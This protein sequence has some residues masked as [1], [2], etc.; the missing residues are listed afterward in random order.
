MLAHPGSYLTTVFWRDL[1]SM[2]LSMNMR[3]R[4]F[5]VRG[6]FYK[7]NEKQSSVS[8]D[9][10]STPRFTQV[11]C[12]RGLSLLNL[13]TCWRWLRTPHP[14]T[15]TVVILHQGIV[16][17]GSIVW[18]SQRQDPFEFVPTIHVHNADSSIWLNTVLLLILLPYLSS[19]SQATRLKLHFTHLNSRY[20]P[21]VLC[22]KSFVYKRE[23]PTSAQ[24]RALCVGE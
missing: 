8:V 5:E 23:C 3:I 6:L 20:S 1:L 16:D 17:N 21:F 22:H 2:S 18:R 9:G 10:L 13:Y 19:K 4:G 11:T 24:L 14:N 12:S 7:M 15:R